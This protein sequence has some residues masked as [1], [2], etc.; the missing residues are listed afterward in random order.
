MSKTLRFTLFTIMFA[1]LLS[2]FALAATRYE[3]EKAQIGTEKAYK[4]ETDKTTASEGIYASNTNGVMFVYENVPLS[5]K[6]VLRCAGQ[7]PSGGIIFSIKK[8]GDTEWT[9]IETLHYF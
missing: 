5:N 4:T 6:V 9:V 2:M 3:C 8:P 1:T 7:Q